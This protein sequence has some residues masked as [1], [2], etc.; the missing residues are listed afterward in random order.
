MMMMMMMI[1][2]YL[3]C[4]RDFSCAAKENVSLS[5]YNILQSFI[6]QTSCLGFS[7]NHEFVVNVVFVWTHLRKYRDISVPV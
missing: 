2:R 5:Y 7:S 1:N 6:D 3:C 4:D